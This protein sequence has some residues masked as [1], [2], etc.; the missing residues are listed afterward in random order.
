MHWLDLLLDTPRRPSFA[1]LLDHAPLPQEVSVK[2]LP[3]A[4]RI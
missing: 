1:A 3:T 2:V 4:E